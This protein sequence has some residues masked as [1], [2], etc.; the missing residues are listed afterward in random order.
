LE[1]PPEAPFV[2]LAV[3]IHF[4]L[5]LYHSKKQVKAAAQRLLHFFSQTQLLGILRLLRAI[6]LLL[7]ISIIN[8]FLQF[9]SNWAIFEIGTAFLLLLVGVLIVTLIL[10]AL[11][12]SSFFEP[13]GISAKY[14]GSSFLPGELDALR[15]KITKA[16]ETDCLYLNPELTIDDLSGSL[17]LQ[18]RMVS[19]TI[20][21]GFG[22]NFF[23][24]INTYRIEAAQQ[25][26][27]ENTDPKLTVLE[28][29][30]QVGFNSKSSFNTQF[31]KKT[32][33]TPS[34]FIRYSKDH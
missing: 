24:F 19:Q 3:Y 13:A 10:K 25:L 4:F 29:M 1:Q 28:V 30:Y 22:K 17:G 27:M 16:M 18:P 26:F 34:E 15:E 14:S 20:N 2:F 11:D 31:R 12:Q 33:K 9:Y 21:A 6:M 23:D 5:Y 8:S 7:I 32:G